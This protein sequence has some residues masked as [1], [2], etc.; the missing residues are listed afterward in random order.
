MKSLQ[1]LNVLVEKISARTGLSND[2]I[3]SQMALAN[4]P[5]FQMDDIILVSPTD[6][7]SMI[8]AWADKIKDSLGL[9]L[10]TTAKTQS[11]TIEKKAMAKGQSLTASPSQASEADSLSW[12]TGFEKL[13]NHQYGPSLKKILPA[14]P[15]QSRAYLEAIA[16]GTDAGQILAQQLVD[17]IV[18]KST[19]NLSSEKV[20]LGLKAKC[21]TLLEL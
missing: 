2:E 16:H 6:F 12:P 17:A 1:E 10:S 8:D 11:P 20:M 21:S 15:N 19:R 9:G 18:K 4:I 7:E 5:V 13:V 3:S 14:D